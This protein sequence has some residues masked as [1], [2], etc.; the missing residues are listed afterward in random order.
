MRASL[1]AVP[2]L[3]VAG[4]S[5]SSTT[6]TPQPSTSV[7]L[8]TAGPTTEP[9]SPT[10]S[11]TP[12]ATATATPARAVPAAEGDVDGDG[13]RDVIQP[14]ATL[15][16]VTL[17]STGQVVTAP[18]HAEDPRPAALLGTADIDRDGRAEVFL[19]TAQGASTQFATPYRFDG[20]S[21]KE[22]QLDGGPARL[23]IGGSVT[24]G[25]GFRCLP[26]G[27]LEVRQADSTDGTTFTVHASDYR[28][29]G[30]QLVLVSSRT[31]KG[32][33][34]TPSVESAYTADCGTVG[35]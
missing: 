15:L 30:T 9:P 26:T 35:D 10:P 32:K 4:C 27:L 11:P 7:P 14:S 12:T 33:Q 6:A 20:T 5:G 18:V 29:S 21:L 16:R 31:G 8:P 28:I 1:L 23:G 2:L 19:Q 25:D 17:S 22:L 13:K 24:H 34:G 3:I